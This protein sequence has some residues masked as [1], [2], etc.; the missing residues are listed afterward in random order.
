MAL[1]PKQAAFYQFCGAQEF[2]APDQLEL[3]RQ[4]LEKEGNLQTVGFGLEEFLE[5]AC[6]SC[7][8]S[9]HFRWH[10]LGRMSHPGCG[11]SWYA[12]PGTYIVEQFRRSFRAGMEVG[13]DAASD[14]RGGASGCLGGLFG[15]L[16]GSIT[17]L[18]FAVFLLPVQAVVSLTQA[19]PAVPLPKPQAGE[20]TSAAAPFCTSCGAPV[21]SEA[22][23]CT[24]CG[25]STHS[26]AGGGSAS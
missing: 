14:S 19:K 9:G 11:W 6:Q 13:A 18:T 22:R 5:T 15:F 17:R 7:G 3:W 4:E 23:F 20:D 16:I 12:D 21:T 10:F 26:T 8:A 1:T 24:K 25:T 2:I